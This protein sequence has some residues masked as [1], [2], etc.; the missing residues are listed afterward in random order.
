MIDLQGKAEQ[1]ANYLEYLMMGLGAGQPHPELDVQIT[2]TA[3]AATSQL[4]NEADQVIRVHAECDGEPVVLDVT[5]R[6]A[7]DMK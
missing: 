6:L 2:G 5:V 3:I 7:D 4:T 1:V